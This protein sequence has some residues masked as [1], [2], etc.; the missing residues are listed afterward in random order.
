MR[1]RAPVA[2]REESAV[3][4]VAAAESCQKE[5]SPPPL[6]HQADQ[7]ARFIE[8]LAALP[9]GERL[10]SGGS[11][12]SAGSLLAHRFRGLGVSTVDELSLASA[13]LLREAGLGL[14]QRQ[15]LGRMLRRNTMERQARINHARRVEANAGRA[16]TG[17]G[18]HHTETGLA[19][20][21]G[22][23]V[24]SPSRPNSAAPSLSPSLSPSSSR[25]EPR[26][27]GGGRCGCGRLRGRRK[28][29]YQT[30]I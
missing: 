1:N 16:G 6:V 21:A 24:S 30:H 10:P 2:P 4:D 28:R 27:G 15:E 11:M 26:D 29:S 17:S 19:A 20:R 3:A 12:L 13:T 8:P 5:Q 23:P 22:L 7:F 18:Q 25:S 14:A 9:G